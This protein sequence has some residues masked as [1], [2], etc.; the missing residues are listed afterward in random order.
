MLIGIEGDVG[1]G[2]TLYLVRCL[3]KDFVY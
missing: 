2:K 1:S 3:K